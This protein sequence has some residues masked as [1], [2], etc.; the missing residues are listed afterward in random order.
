MFRRAFD[1]ET[2]LKGFADS[3]RDLKRSCLGVTSRNLRNGSDVVAFLVALDHDI[4]LTW[5]KIL[6]FPSS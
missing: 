2:Q 3:L 4:E 6:D 1:F 5:H